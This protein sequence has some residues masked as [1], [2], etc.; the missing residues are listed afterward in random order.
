VEDFSVQKFWGIIQTSSEPGGKTFFPEDWPC[1][2][3]PG[4]L[5]EY[6]DLWA[7]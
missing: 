1:E 7:L 2:K 3:Q 4:I 6:L 5:P